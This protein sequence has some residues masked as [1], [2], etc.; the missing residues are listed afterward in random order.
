MVNETLIDPTSPA[1]TG[2]YR[3]VVTATHDRYAP[4]HP[5]GRST[6]L[7]ANCAD[8]GVARVRSHASGDLRIESSHRIGSASSSRRRRDRR[9]GGAVSRVSDRR[10]ALMFV[11]PSPSRS[12]TSE[13]GKRMDSESRTAVG[14]DE[15][16]EALRRVFAGPAF[17]RSP[18]LRRLLEYLVERAL[19]GDQQIKEYTIAVA[20]LGRPGSFD[21]DHDASVRVQAGRLRRSLNTY[22]TAQG[23]DD[24][25]RI[26]LP[27]G[28]YAVVFERQRTTRQ[29]AVPSARWW[30]GRSEVFIGVLVLAIAGLAAPAMVCLLGT[31]S[32]P[33]V[34]T[35]AVMTPTLD[36]LPTIV[37]AQFDDSAAGID[38]SVMLG[39]RRRLAAVFSQFETANVVHATGHEPVESPRPAAGERTYELSAAVTR[40][41]DSVRVRFQ[42]ADQSA[43]TVAWTQAFDVEPGDNDVQQKRIVHRLATTLLQ[44]YGVITSRERAH[45]LHGGGGDWRYR[46]VLQAMDA[47]RDADEIAYAAARTCLEQVI[48]SDPAHTLAYAYLASILNRYHQ[49]GVSDQPGLLDAALAAARRAVHTNPVSAQAHF[50]LFITRFNMRDF[51]AAEAAMAQARALNP[52]DLLIRSEYG[53]R[54]V[55]L[56]R[57]D[58]GMAILEEVAYAFQA[59]PCTHGLY[60]FLGHYL[61]GDMGA[62][63]RRVQELTCPSYPFVFLVKA[64]VAAHDGDKEAARQAFASLCAL[65]PAW[66]SDLRA[67]LGRTIPDPAIVERILGDLNAA[68]VTAGGP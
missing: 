65:M 31:E 22:Y 19:A 8:A 17:A 14:G 42:L 3:V 35:A 44:P 47:L 53:G 23:R 13:M 57:V 7:P 36:G 26:M 62:A 68:G 38:L 55:T 11:K 1:V 6:F 2:R 54:L 66:R 9:S 49:H 64:L 15:V 60:A 56:G 4:H 48:E 25:V 40:Q 12:A 41:A 51:D 21:P 34:A 33:R 39:L 30:R 28:S 63:R 59:P 43:G 16:H 20:A 46:C 52:D 24:P 37:V 27:V 67:I 32:G 10:A 5:T 58:E 29:G 50:A 18:Q 45:H 61:R